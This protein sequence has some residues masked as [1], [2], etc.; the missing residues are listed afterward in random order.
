MSKAAAHEKERTIAFP[1]FL[2]IILDIFFSFCKWE[3]LCGIFSCLFKH[4]RNKYFHSN[5]NAATNK[6]AVE[7]VQSSSQLRNDQVKYRGQMQKPNCEQK[8]FAYYRWNFYCMKGGI[9]NSQSQETKSRFWSPHR[10]G[11]KQSAPQCHG[12]WECG[13]NYGISRK[14]TWHSKML[15]ASGNVD[16]T[17]ICANFTWVTINLH[18]WAGQISFNY[19][20]CW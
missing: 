19:Q 6:E 5:A 10:T 20:C 7:N 8:T 14:V 13:P 11:E 17:L 12:S 2:N 16:G 9:L 15:I 4:A 1:L 3:E 18:A